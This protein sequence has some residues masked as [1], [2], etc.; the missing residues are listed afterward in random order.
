MLIRLRHS[1]AVGDYYAV[2]RFLGGGRKMNFW[3]VSFIGALANLAG[4]FSLIG[5]G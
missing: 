4:S 3:V 1:H 2:F 5:Q